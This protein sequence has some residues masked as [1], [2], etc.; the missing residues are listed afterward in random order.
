MGRTIRF[1]LAPPLPGEVAATNVRCYESTT[2]DG[3]FNQ[4]DDEALAA[5][6]VD[7][8]GFY[9]WNV[10]ALVE[11][12]VKIGTYVLGDG[13]VRMS[14]VILGPL[15]STIAKTTIEVDL[16]DLGVDPKEG[17]AFDA[18]L[19]GGT[20]AFDGVI[21][22]LDPIQQ[23]TDINGRASF[24]VPKGAT[25][26]LTSSV[27]GVPLVIDTANLDFIKAGSVI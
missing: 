8:D 21:V 16:V 22:S 18:K 11:N 20:V 14:D 3:Q 26:K 23:T 4:T 5:I 24:A 25:V 10:T 19:D 12:Y 15:V 6:P 13:T 27:L 7:A 9:S 1:K 17:V 2:P